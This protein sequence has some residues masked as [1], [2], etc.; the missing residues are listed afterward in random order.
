MPL[1]TT[2]K[3]KIKQPTGK[4]PIIKTTISIIKRRQT[5]SLGHN[6]N[7]IIKGGSS[8][9]EINEAISSQSSTIKRLDRADRFS[10][11]SL[12]LR[13]LN[14]MD[15]DFMKHSL[16]RTHTNSL[17]E[18]DLTKNNIF[19]SASTFKV[20]FFVIFYLFTVMILIIVSNYTDDDT[21]DSVFSDSS[22][23]AEYI[24]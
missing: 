5:Y 17:L 2:K 8:I 21:I 12:S 6:N 22:G 3:S 13:K 10:S 19:S 7:N 20:R 24:T 11:C 15:I 1:T 18:L 23:K 16:T 4:I 14:L 9:N